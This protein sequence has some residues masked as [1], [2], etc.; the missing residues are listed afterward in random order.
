V[1]LSTAS[2]KPISVNYAT[3]NGTATTADH[4]YQS[5]SGTLTFAPGET[6]KTISI[7][8]YGDTKKEADETF[9][10]NLS[11]ATNATLLDGTGIGAILNDDGPHH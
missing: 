9:S 11:G 5:Q 10:V 7:V 1:S 2:E 4:D 8:I 3:A 6:S